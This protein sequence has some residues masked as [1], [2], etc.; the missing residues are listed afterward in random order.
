MFFSIRL[1]DGH[2][3]NMYLNINYTPFRRDDGS[4]Q[5]IL[6]FIDDITSK[7]LDRKRLEEAEAKFRA[8]ANSL[9]LMVWSTLPNGMPNFYNQRWCDY[10]KIP[11]ETAAQWHWSHFVHPEDVEDMREAWAESVR[12]GTNY[13]HRARLLNSAS[14][15]YRW[16]QAQAVPVKDQSGNVVQW[17]GTTTDIHE[18]ILLIEELN[19]ARTSAEIANLAKSS[20]LANMSHEI[21]TPL[22]AILGFTKILNDSDRVEERDKYSKIIA[23]NGLA[24]SKL[25]DDILDLTKVEAGRLDIEN[26]DFLLDEFLHD[27]YDEFH[28]IA[29]AKG[30]EFKLETDSNLP[31]AIKSDPNRL[32]QILVN[33]LGNSIKFTSQGLVKISVKSLESEGPEHVLQFAIEDSGVGLTEEQAERLFQPFAQADSSMTRKYGG[34]GLGLTLSRK[35]AQALNGDVRIEKSVLGE[36]ST[37]IAIV[38]VNPSDLAN[39]TEAQASPPGLIPAEGGAHILVVDDAPDNRLLVELVLTMAGM[40]VDVATNGAEAAAK[41]EKSE[42]DVIL[43]DMQMPVLDGYAA[44]RLIR[45]RGYT[46]PILALSAHVMEDDKKKTL[47]AGCN[48]HLS[49]PLNPDVLLRKIGEYWQPRFH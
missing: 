49:K 26:T 7:V 28:G 4:I 10:I 22:N 32:R 40:K 9:P 3:K 24:L 41:A 23:R 5:G 42:Y 12:T 36:G 35:V 43:M 1:D 48:S 27:I 13:E 45:S 33:L 47:E 34:T 21:R 46:K 37:F 44:T 14:G 18:T 6:V 19:A 11:Y 20:F 39:K 31:A 17:Y 15:E 29:A 8:M 25:I 16:I 2:Q 30:I 38:R